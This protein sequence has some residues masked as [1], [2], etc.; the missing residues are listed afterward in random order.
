MY[1]R[2]IYLI[3]FVLVL[4]LVGNIQ[5]ATIDWTDAAGGHLWSKPGNWE[6]DT[7]PTP[8]DTANI[9]K[10]PGPIIK[11]EGAV[12]DDVL[13]GRGSNTGEL[14]VDGGTLTVTDWL[15]VARSNGSEGTL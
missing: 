14:I 12:A 6:N 2:L 4:F 11:N 3:S 9:K 8:A 10:V 15:A 13:V 1:T 5:A 7:L